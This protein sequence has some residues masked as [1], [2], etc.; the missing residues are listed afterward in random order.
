MSAANRRGGSRVD[1][2]PACARKKEKEK[3]GTKGSHLITL[4]SQNAGT[5]QRP[6]ERTPDLCVFGVVVRVQFGQTHE[7]LVYEKDTQ[8]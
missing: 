5:L 7:K 1:G 3:A 6:I 8:H 2:L 4:G